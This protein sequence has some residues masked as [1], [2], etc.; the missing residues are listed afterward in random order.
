MAYVDNGDFWS[1]AGPGLLDLGV[2]MY[3][4]N[5]AMR[6]AEERLKRSRG[7]LYDANMGAAQGMLAQAGTFDPQAH[8]AERF[9]AQQAL[10]KPVQDKAH[11]DLL[12]TLRAKGMLGAATHNPGLE[13]GT[14]D[15]GVAVNPHVAAFYAAQN[16]QRSKDAY[17]ALDS[18]QAYLDK[19]LN[20]SGMLQRSAGDAQRMGLEAMRT[21][22]SRA[23][24]THQL[25]KGGLGVLKDSGVLKDVFKPGGML[26]GAMDW[27]KGI[28][29]PQ[30]AL[31]PMAGPGAFESGGMPIYTPP[32]MFAATPDF[33]I[34][35]GNWY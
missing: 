13:G 11:T 16:A 24:A 32:M 4:R 35:Y 23:T 6:E 34:D 1:K 30:P 12:R 19:I 22:P 14:T 29:N 26:G 9:A 31:P 25:L 10:I 8:A 5:A 27:L 2:G 7:P 20:R 28:L 3:S 21:Q 33:E 15:A 17:S 18:G